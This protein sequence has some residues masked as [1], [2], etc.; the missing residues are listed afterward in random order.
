MSLIFLLKISEIKK[1]VLLRF[2]FIRRAKYVKQLTDLMRWSWTARVLRH[3]P[4][5]GA[6]Q[7][8]GRWIAGELTTASRPGGP[9]QIHRR[10]RRVDFCGRSS[11]AYPSSCC[12][13]TIYSVDLRAWNKKKKIIEPS[14]YRRDQKW[15]KLISVSKIWLFDQILFIFLRTWANRV[16]LLCTLS[17]K[18][19][20]TWLSETYLQISKISLCSSIFHINIKCTNM[21]AMP[22]NLVQ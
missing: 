4:V 1:F 3:C 17:K 13:I 5:V 10:R 16:V 9:L 14:L 2:F 15:G 11:L 22:R 6:S 18:K 19:K 21:T 20:K 12:C 8:A 7:V